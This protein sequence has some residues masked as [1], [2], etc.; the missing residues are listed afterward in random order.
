M[1]G[2]SKIWT[3]DKADAMFS[4]YIRQR[5]GRCMHPRCTRK[6][7]TY[8]KGM[9]NSHYYG[10]GEW[11]TRFDPENC[12][13]AHPGCHLFQWEKTKNT[14]YREFKIKQLGLKRFKAMEK[15][16]MDAKKVGAPHVKQS[17]RILACMEF[18]RKVGFVDHNYR[19]IKK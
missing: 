6:N 19:Q 5:D 7:D 1:L 12:D 16:V 15:R 11:V 9:Q 4:Q 2:N 13:T 3:T 10:R 8:V 18:L 14:E 17:D